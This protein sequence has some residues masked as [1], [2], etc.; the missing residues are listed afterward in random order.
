MPSTLMPAQCIMYPSHE[1]FG[2]YGTA[3]NFTDLAHKWDAFHA[4]TGCAVYPLVP[5]G[6]IFHVYWNAP[7][8]PLANLMSIESFL[9][10]Q[11]LD[12]GHKLW[13]WWAPTKPPPDDIVERFTG[14]ESPYRGYIRFLPFVAEVEVLGTC[15][16]VRGSLLS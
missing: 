4:A 10:T 11:D 5:G 13:F 14:P 6:H 2:G 12:A 15:Y 8:W 7:D 1:E 16:E 3:S 9:A